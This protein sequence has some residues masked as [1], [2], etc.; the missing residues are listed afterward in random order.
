MADLL[1]EIGCEELPADSVLPMARHLADALRAALDEAG[2]GGGVPAVFATPRRLAAR[3]PDVR[4]RQA[5]R[6]VER[7]GPAVAAAFEGGEPGGEPTRALR[8]FLAKAGA[9][10]SDVVVVGEGGKAKVAV[11]IVEPGRELEDVVREA[12][13]DALRRMPMPRRM[14]WSDGEA[15][16]LRPVAWLAALH[17][18]RALPIGAFGLDAG[19]TTRGHRVHAPGPHAL[20][21][22][23]AYESTLREAFV[24]PDFAARR[25]RVVEGVRA[26]AARV[27]GE[28][29]MDDS[30]VDE[31]TNLVE[32]PVALAGRFEE[33]FLALPKEALVQTMQENQRYFALLAP[34]GALLPAF[35]TVANLESADPARVVDGN[36][37]VIRPRFADT[38]FFWEQDARA[39]LASRT[40]A[41]DRVLFHPELGSVGDRVRR[42]VRLAAELA[43]ALG[44]DAEA[45]AAAASLAKSDLVSAIV[46]ELPE[47]QGIAGRYY[48]ARDGHPEVVARA[49]EQHWWPLQ[50][51]APLPADAVGTAVALADRLDALV[52]IFGIGRRPTGAKDPFA[53]RRAAIGVCRLLVE[54]GHGLDLDDAI[55]AAA[56]AYAAPAA[57]GGAELPS[58]DPA[59]VREFV[60][61]RLRVHLV[62]QVGRPADAVEAVLAT[63]SAA[64]S[65]V[66][67]RVRAIE[68]FRA[69]PAAG[70][71]SRAAK[72]CGNLLRRAEAGDVAAAV[73]PA[74]LVEPAERALGAALDAARPEVDAALAGGDYASAMDRTA[75]LAEPVDRFFDEVM[76]M[77]EDPTLRANRLALLA[78]LAAL[79]NRTA[80]LSRLAP[81]EGADAASGGAARA[82][83]TGT[84]A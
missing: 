68:A 62:E 30:L 36:E 52:G 7:Q 45:V 69:T 24:E 82:A 25:A 56:R 49:V 8:G 79:S 61:E 40:E 15:E 10:V 32:W 31:V 41:L 14:R 57:E 58:L 80:D 50:A 81:G 73:D 1:I 16:F 43:P 20:A 38:M 54:P 2:L 19:E 4:A 76:V 65:D 34:D 9:E 59:E 17:G 83:A 12:L 48:A 67:A 75:T 42:M 28:P 66:D 37:R 78:A 11:R 23:G 3:W 13:D 27:G 39:T 72:R 70:S 64:P 77:D 5:D 63:G 55:G 47:M 71:L 21:D 18:D 51:G 35:V 84:G 6:A 29:V 33:R 53:L 22:G 26:E 44:A 60:L 46:E 74:R